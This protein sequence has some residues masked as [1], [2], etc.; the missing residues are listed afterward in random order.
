MIDKYGNNISI[1]SKEIS[2]SYNINL[3]NE[4]IRIFILCFN[5]LLPNQYLN[6]YIQNKILKHI[7]ICQI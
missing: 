1:L 2:T 6:V 5:K 3:Y 4:H 7:S